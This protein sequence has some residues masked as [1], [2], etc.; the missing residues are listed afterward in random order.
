MCIR[1]CALRIGEKVFHVLVLLG[2]IG[3]LASAI[4]SGMM[5]GGRDGFMAGGIQ[6]IISWSGTL[7][8]ALVV[9]SL[10][11]IRHSL[12]ASQETCTKNVESKE[13]NSNG[14]NDVKKGCNT[15]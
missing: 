13:C 10:L 2:L 12:C 8:I 14:T 6:L 15:H 5:L 3:G 7:I 1:K 9:Y 11:D 4:N